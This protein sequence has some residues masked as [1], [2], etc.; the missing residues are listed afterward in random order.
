MSPLARWRKSLSLRVLVSSSLLIFGIVVGASSLLLNQ[1][2]NGVVNS[3]VNESL[4]D[5]IVGLEFAVDVVDSF[6]PS[7]SPET[8]VDSIVAT[9]NRRSGQPAAYEVLMLSNGDGPERSTNSVLSSSVSPALLVQVFG[10]DNQQWEFGTINYVNG[11]KVPAVVVGAPIYINNQQ[12]YGLFL[13]YPTAKQQELVDVVRSA[14]LFISSIL[15]VSLIF[16][17][18]VIT[19]RITEPIRQA[20][21]TAQKI[22][23]GMLDQ[24]LE[25]SGEDEVA[26]WATSFNSM[27]ASLEKQ[28]TKLKELSEVQQRFVSDVSHELRTPVTTVRLAADLL[29]SKRIEFPPDVA[30]AAELLQGELD[31]FELMLADLLELSRIDAGVSQLQLSEHSINQLIERVLDTLKT[32]AQAAQVEIEFNSSSAEG[33]VICDSRRIERAL[34]NLINN[35]IIHSGSSKIVIECQFTESDCE[36][37]VTDFGIGLTDEQKTHVFQRFWRSDPARSRDNGGSGLGLSIAFEDVSQHEGSIFVT[38]S[39]SRGGAKFI[40]RLPLV[41]SG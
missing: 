12:Q 13:L 1:V 41:K 33:T 37:S 39:T 3:K 20:A 36:I 7:Q 18:V 30:R 5:A 6:G 38:D 34:R 24:R 17:V 32:L 8:V 11:K 4:V 35:A 21:D 10:T 26:R 29:H 31:R 14:I 40:I 25:V 22:A 23:S 15:I 19:R 2:Q 27:A 9:L 28:I 16:V